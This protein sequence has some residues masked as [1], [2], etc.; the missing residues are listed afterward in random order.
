MAPH[1]RSLVVFAWIVTVAVSGGCDVSDKYPPVAVDPAPPAVEGAMVPTP[2]FVHWDQFPV[3]TQVTRRKTVTNPDGSITVTTTQR[4]IEKTDKKITVQQQKMV[5]RP[6]GRTEFPAQDLV[7]AAAFRLPPNLTEEQFA[8]PALKAKSTG[9][10]TIEVAG[11]TYDAEVF[12]WEEANEAGPMPI[13]IWRS[14]AV[15]GQILREEMLTQS[16]NQESKE[17]VIEFVIP[18]SDSTSP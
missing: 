6:E 10:E 11:Q 5:D 2:Q 16:I 12:E 1:F 18:T 8:L 3:D 7:F 15:P 4:L 17:E 13:K 14:N 9:R